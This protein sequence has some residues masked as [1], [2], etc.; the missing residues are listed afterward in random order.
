MKYRLVPSL[1]LSLGLL[2]LAGLAH[3]DEPSRGKELHQANCVSCHVNMTGGDGSVLY[4]RNNRR[5]QSLTGLEAQVRRC[6]SNLELK[7]FDDDIEAV[8]KYLNAT[9]Y[10]FDK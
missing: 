5:V 3:A 1:L 9:Y 7:W 6:E 2:G 8:T 4:T 10:H